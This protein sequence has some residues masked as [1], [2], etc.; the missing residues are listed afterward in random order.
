MGWCTLPILSEEVVSVGPELTTG[1][2]VSAEKTQGG[3]RDTNHDQDTKQP[4]SF[5]QVA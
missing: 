2:T 1:D 5:L 3:R 4:N